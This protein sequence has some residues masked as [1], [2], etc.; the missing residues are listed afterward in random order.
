MEVSK[1]QPQSFDT[2]PTL[3]QTGPFQDSRRPLEAV[4]GLAQLQCSGIPGHR[5][6]LGVAAAELHF[7]LMP[8]EGLRQ[9]LARLAETKKGPE[10][11]KSQPQLTWGHSKILRDLVSSRRFEREG[12]CLEVLG[13][14]Q[15][16]GRCLI[17]RG[18]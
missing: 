1:S 14:D 8:A 9:R 5:R 11:S 12:D 2:V 16:V 6:V 10:K 15:T 18:T 7:G 13:I 3:P 17:I 4:P